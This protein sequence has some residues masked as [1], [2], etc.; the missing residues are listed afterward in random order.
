MN[1]AIT[2]HDTGVVPVLVSVKG[3]IIHRVLVRVVHVV[4]PLRAVVVDEEI[5]LI[6]RA[7]INRTRI[8]RLGLPINRIYPRIDP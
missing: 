8:H 5:G 3:W 1:L 7:A 2:R 6:A 4:A